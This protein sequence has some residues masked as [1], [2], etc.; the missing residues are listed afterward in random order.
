[1]PALLFASKSQTSRGATKPEQQSQRLAGQV[2]IRMFTLALKNVICII[3][4]ARNQH[5]DQQG[6]A[7]MPQGDQKAAC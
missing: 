6:K 5:N 2:N 7:A 3:F 1:M 4:P